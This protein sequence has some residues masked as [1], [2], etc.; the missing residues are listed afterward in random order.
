MVNIHPIV[1]IGT[2]TSIDHVDFMITPRGY[3]GKYSG[4]IL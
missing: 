1:F 3:G 2:S 4:D